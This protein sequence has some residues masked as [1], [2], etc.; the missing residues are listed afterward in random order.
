MAAKVVS[1]KPV[2]V[3]VVEAL[4]VDL[5]RDDVGDEVVGWVGLPVLDDRG[6]VLAHR[7]RGRRGHRVVV[8]SFV[9]VERPV[10]EPLVVLGGDSQHAGDDLHGK[11]AGHFGDQVGPVTPGE[12]VDDAVNSGADERALPTFQGRRPEGVGNQVAVAAVFLTVHGQDDRAH[13]RPHG[14]GVD[15]ARK[16]FGV[17]QHELDIGVPSHKPHVGAGPPEPTDRPAAPALRPVVVDVRAVVTYICVSHVH[18]STPAPFE[19]S[20]LAG[21]PPRSAGALV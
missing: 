13:D 7:R 6:E 2:D 15:T 1:Q 19:A 20:S 21:R 16:T 11:A 12:A 17:P 4:A 3:L 9:H 8:G 18:P 14:V 5:G 10:V